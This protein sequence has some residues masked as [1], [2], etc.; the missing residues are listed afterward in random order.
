MKKFV[1]II[2]GMLLAAGQQV[3]AQSWL[4]KIGKRVK[5]KPAKVTWSGGFSVRAGCWKCIRAISSC[6][7]RHTH[8]SLNRRPA[9]R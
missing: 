8:L 9:G 6:L 4:E 7:Y 2:S 3:S 5:E 1:L